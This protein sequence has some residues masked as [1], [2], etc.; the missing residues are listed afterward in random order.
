MPILL[1][2]GRWAARSMGPALARADDAGSL[3]RGGDEGVLH[4][5]GGRGADGERRDRLR[6]CPVHA[7]VRRRQARDRA[8]GSRRD[9]DLTITADPHA[10]VRISPG[11]RS[12]SR[13]KATATSRPPP[14]DLPLQHRGRDQDLAVRDV[15][16]SG[17]DI[18]SAPCKIV[19]R[20]VV[21]CAA[22]RMRSLRHMDASTP[23]STSTT[24]RAKARAVRSRSSVVSSARMRSASTTS[25]CRPA[26]RDASTTRIGVEPG[27]GAVR[28][29]R[30]GR[31]R[32][33]GDEIDLKPGRF[34]RLD[35]SAVRCPVAGPDGLTLRHLRL[36]R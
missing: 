12:S 36:A 30:L 10:L 8:R 20:D 1:D 11:C 27:R 5:R 13:R 6:R 21:R 9:P 16:R 2:L 23:S 34:V 29:R 18:G 31:L 32:V 7:A 14:A 4:A 28:R 22:Y 15:G 3:V 35:P 24:C 25:S 26:P 33:D 17:R 19:A